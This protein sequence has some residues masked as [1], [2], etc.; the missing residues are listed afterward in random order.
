M[1]GGEEKDRTKRQEGRKDGRKEGRK[2]Q[3]GTEEEQSGKNAGETAK[4]VLY[5]YVYV[6][7]A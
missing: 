7:S 3:I 4:C 6:M 2:E 1:E 5:S